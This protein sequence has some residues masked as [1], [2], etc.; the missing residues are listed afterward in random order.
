MD[1]LH[2][3]ARAQLIRGHK[4]PPAAMEALSHAGGRREET[5]T[6]QARAKH[7]AVPL[8]ER[9]RRRQR[10]NRSQH[11]QPAHTGPLTGSCWV[12]AACDIIIAGIFAASE[13]RVTAATRAVARSA[14]AAAAAAAA[15]PRRRIGAGA[16]A[17]C[18]P[19]EPSDNM[20]AR[21]AA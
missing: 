21:S 2:R 8:R 12:L 1:D 13:L 7:A 17:P 6:Q 3:C 9:A 15:A 5:K 19:T 11:A 18:C 16:A 4:L 20:R 14:T 10:T